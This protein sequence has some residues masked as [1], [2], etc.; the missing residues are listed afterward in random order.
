MRSLK[1]FIGEEDPNNENREKPIAKNYQRRD[2]ED[3]ATRGR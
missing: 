3:A 2:R 1:L